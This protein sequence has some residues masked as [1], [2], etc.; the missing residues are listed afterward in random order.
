MGELAKRPKKRFIGLQNHGSPVEFSNV[1]IK[2]LTR[3]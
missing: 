1:E 3:P 2:A